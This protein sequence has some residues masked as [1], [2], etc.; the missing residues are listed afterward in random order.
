VISTCAYLKNSS[1]SSLK[2][3]FSCSDLSFLWVVG[4]YL[5]S[6]GSK[7]GPVAF[8]LVFSLICAVPL[9]RRK[10]L[11]WTISADATAW[12][13]HRSW[14]QFHPRHVKY[15][16]IFKRSL[17]WFPSL[18]SMLV[19]FFLPTT[20]HLL[21]SGTDLVPHYQFSISLNWLMNQESDPRR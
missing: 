20:S 4:I 15:L 11:N 9:F 1:C 17:L 19:L 5:H 14:R 6:L 12:L 13:R 8:L 2:S 21:Y 3:Y 7:S 16:G 10:T 18:C